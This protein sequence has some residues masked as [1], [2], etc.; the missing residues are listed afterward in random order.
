MIERFIRSLFFSF[1][2]YVGQAIGCLLMVYVPFVP[3]KWALKTIEAYMAFFTKLEEI[4]IPLNHVVIG[5]EN[6][7][8]EG[9]F[10]FACK[11][12]SA[13]ETYKLHAWLDDPA[14]IMKKELASIPLWGWY[15]RKMRAIF[16]DR[17]A[18]GGMFA[19]L[20]T[21]AIKAKKQGRPIVVFPEGTRSDPYAF[22]PYKKGVAVLYEN[23]QVPIVP[24]ALNSGLFWPR[25]GFIKKPGTVTVKILPPIM[26]GLS[27]EQALNQLQEVLEAETKTL[28]PPR[29]NAG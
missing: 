28:L 26:P 25:H 2:F 1:T 4:I 16:V 23:L 14:V 15:A 21:G 17:K 22:R 9:C 12:Q 6:L 13:W 27:A 3:H 7:P 20:I 18:K 5:A 10:L 11:H 8:K 24:V 29:G 19:S